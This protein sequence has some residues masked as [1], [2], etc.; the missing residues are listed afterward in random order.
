MT[1]YYIDGTKY[2]CKS[3]YKK[4]YLELGQQL[5]KVKSAV[6]GRC[7]WCAQENEH[8]APLAKVFPAM[9]PDRLKQAI[10]EII[11][12]AYQSSQTVREFWDRT[13]KG[14]TVM[15]DGRIRWMFPKGFNLRQ[16]QISAIKDVAPGTRY[17]VKFDHDW[18]SGRWTLEVIL[19]RGGP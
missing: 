6:N 15:P 14:L 4:R 10:A 1:E 5:L 13:A 9:R 16:D 18:R 7:S 3:H 19:K 17:M 11:A 12:P 2:V 8:L